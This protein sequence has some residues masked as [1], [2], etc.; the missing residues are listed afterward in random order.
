VHNLSQQQKK[1]NFEH[2]IRFK[3]L[4]KLFLKYFSFSEE[5]SDI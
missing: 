3:F 2:K 4:Y 1:K 5:L